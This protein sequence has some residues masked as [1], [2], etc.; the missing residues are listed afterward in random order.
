MKYT[1]FPGCSLK[2][3]AKPYEE[4]F[5]EISK[6]LG[7]EIEELPDWNCCGA[8][9]YMA[10]D[11]G[12]AFGMAIRSLARAEAIGKDMV[13]PCSNCYAVLNK[14]KDYFLKYPELRER[15]ASSL[16]EVGLSFEG[17]V[18]IKHPLDVIVNE[19]GLE[20]VK[21][22]V[23][24]PLK[25]L[26]VVPYYGCLVV[27]PYPIFDHPCYP[28]TLDRLIKSLGAEPVPYPLK[29][30]CC[31]ASLTGTVEEAGYRI[32]YHHLRASKKSGAHLIVTVC[33]LCQFNLEAYQDKIS[34]RYGEDLRIP[35]LFFT[36]LMGLAFGIDEERLGLKRMIV[37]PQKVLEEVL[38]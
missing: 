1:Y 8:T 12:A 16:R 31:G 23:K 7:I 19:V 21:E 29:T 20:K 14:T 35:V 22:C 3:T 37:S 17:K 15:M 36:Q 25:G 18:S 24:R 2:G 10:I 26:K 30:L 34:K 38:A 9:T 6:S 4:S 13:V 32:V 28:T 5:L 27:R 11:E 33:P